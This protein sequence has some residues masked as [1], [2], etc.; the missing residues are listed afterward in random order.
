MLNQCILTGN[1][2]ND[3]EVN[4]YGEGQPIASFNLAFQSGK[5]KPTGWIKVVS[6]NKL[7]EVVQKYLHSGARVGIIG[8]LDQKH[9]ETNE[10]VQ[11]NS[12][13]VIAQGIEFIR[14]DGRGFE[15]GQPED[16]IPF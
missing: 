2:G 5:K 4:F 13:Q 10:G 12:F 9:W 14:T 3:P 11:R 7:A 8:I 16:E 6:F 15:K 1:L